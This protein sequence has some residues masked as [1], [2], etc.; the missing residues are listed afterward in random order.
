MTDSATAE[1]IDHPAKKAADAAKA[2]KRAA[3][4]EEERP[5]ILFA[6][7]HAAAGAALEAWEAEQRARETRTKIGK[8]YGDRVKTANEKLAAAVAEDSK[9]EAARIS[10]ALDNAKARAKKL[11]AEWEEAAQAD[12]GPVGRAFRSRAK[13][14]DERAEAKA[15][16]GAKITK[17][18]ERFEK[19][20]ASLKAQAAQLKLAL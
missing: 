19:V 7:A 18:A 2:A 8:Q 3:K 15:A 16:A 4:A 5:E 20:M 1:V 13:L 12:G 11:R 6:S 10:A 9:G 17:R 14:L